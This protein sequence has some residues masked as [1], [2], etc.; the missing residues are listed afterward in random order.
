M[1]VFI[2][3]GTVRLCPPQIFLSLELVL[4]ETCQQHWGSLA[5]TQDPIHNTTAPF[6]EAE[7]GALGA[8]YNASQGFHNVT[9]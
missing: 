3:Y 5:Y 8:P 7:G 1:A 4:T 6:E 2:I 9:M